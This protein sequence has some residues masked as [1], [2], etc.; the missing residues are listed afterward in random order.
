[1]QLL[2]LGDLAFVAL[3]GELY[4]RLGLHLRAVSPLQDTVLITH[5]A[6]CCE[7]NGRVIN[8]GYI[9]DDEAMADGAFGSRRTR[10]Q[11]GY[12]RQALEK[13]MLSLFKNAQ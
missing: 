9:Y 8:N 13:T 12:I 5:C 2:R 10:M 11:P 1:M 3:S 4:T 6:N 7:I